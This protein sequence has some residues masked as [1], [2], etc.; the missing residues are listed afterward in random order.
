[1]RQYCSHCDGTSMTSTHDNPSSE[2]EKWAIILVHGVGDTEPTQMID[3]VTTAMSAAN[4]NLMLR[5]DYELIKAREIDP[6]TCERS[7]F[8]VYL[9]RGLTKAGRVVFAE[10]H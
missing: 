5:A 10:V 2:K 4:P 7:T 3:A 6:A 8:P 1:M 9:K